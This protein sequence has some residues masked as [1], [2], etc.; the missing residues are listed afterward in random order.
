MLTRYPTELRADMQ[1]YYGID[2][3]RLGDGLSAWHVSAC[4][5]HLPPGS[6]TLAA[7]DPMLKWDFT[8]HLL[9]KI[10]RMLSAEHIPYPWEEADDCGLLPEF[11][12][13][14]VEE[15]EEWYGQEWKEVDA[16]CRVIA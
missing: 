13:L 7:A 12:P 3:G 15:M 5:A 6:A 10:L 14:P 16:P 1:R 11:A 8:Q 9:F 4:A 2:I